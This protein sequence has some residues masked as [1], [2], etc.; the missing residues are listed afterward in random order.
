MIQSEKDKKGDA[1][2]MAEI[3]KI[4]ICPGVE[5]DYHY[6][7]QF[8][9]S[10]FAVGFKYRVQTGSS[11]ADTVLSR[12]ICHS[13]ADYPTPIQFNRRLDELYSAE[14]TNSSF[15]AGD[16]RFAIFQVTFLNDAF[17]SEIPDFS[18]AVLSFLSGMILCPNLSG[19][20]AFSETETTLEKHAI[21]D[22]ILAIKNNKRSYAISRIVEL[23]SDESRYEVPDY[24]TLA[25]VEKITPESLFSRYREMLYHSEIRFSYVGSLPVGSVL[26]FVEE[27]FAP[28]CKPRRPIKGKLAFSKKK[29]AV[30]VRKTVEE[31]DGKQA[32]LCLGY[33]EPIGIEDDDDASVLPL[34]SAVLSDCP[35]SMLFS[36]VREKHGYCYSIGAL[37]HPSARTMTIYAGIDAENADA[38]RRAVKS[39]LSDLK[40]EK[41]QDGLFE[42]ARSFV[43]AAILALTDEVEAFAYYVVR[44]ALFG[45]DTDVERM[46]SKTMALS[47]SDL[48]RIARK[49]RPDTVYL[50]APKGDMVDG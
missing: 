48:A 29:A 6:T 42:S 27:L 1:D 2:R 14:L 15:R 13:S 50:L 28:I 38:V 19:K 3:Q 20:A 5:L 18:R 34:L 36:E 24:G 47:Q 32:I 12:V 26:S 30:P 33:R 4:T 45:W 25:E 43:R 21:H 23:M 37:L 11:S 49:I 46:I 39:V 44:R 40:R 35:M 41:L 31:T 8:K 16:F 9:C 7:D 17:A 22:R 10:S